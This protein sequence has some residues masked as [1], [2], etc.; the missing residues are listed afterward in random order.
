MLRKMLEI[1]KPYADNYAD[2]DGKLD[3]EEKRLH[4]QC[5]E[6][7]SWIFLSLRNVYLF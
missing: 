7:F 6:F 4:E 5:D 3:K 1:M 2:V